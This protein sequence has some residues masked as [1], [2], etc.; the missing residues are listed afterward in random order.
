MKSDSP[1][2]H[3]YRML[4]VYS[5]TDINAGIDEHILASSCW[6]FGLLCDR[7]YDSSLGGLS[8]ANPPASDES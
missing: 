1:L 7:L 2:L 3:M 6:H 4:I 5:V 8:P